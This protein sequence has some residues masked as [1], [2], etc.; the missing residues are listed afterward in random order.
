[1]F[2]LNDRDCFRKRTFLSLT[3]YPDFVQPDLSTLLPDETVWP[4]DLA[5]PSPEMLCTLPLLNAVM[6]D[7]TKL[8]ALRA[9]CMTFL[10]QYQQN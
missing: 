1:M 7:T 10:W 5:W 6:Y 8:T 4:T 2:T 3:V 9:S